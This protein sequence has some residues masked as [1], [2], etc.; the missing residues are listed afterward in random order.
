MPVYV[1]TTFNDPS[2]ATGTTVASGVN[3]MDQIV[4]FFQDVRGVHG[5]LASGGTFSTLDDPLATVGN[6]QNTQ[7]FGINDSG[8]IVGDYA[9]ASGIHGFLYDPSAGVFPPYFTL[10]DPLATG[11]EGTVA[12]GINATRQ[13]V[14][15]YEDASFHFHG[16]LLSGGVYTTLD[17]P[18]ATGATF[19]KGINGSGQIV[20]SYANAT[21]NHAFLYDPN[22]GTYTTLDDPLAGSGPGNGTFARGINDLGSSGLTPT[23]PA[24]TASSIAVAYTP[25]STIPSPPAPAPSLERLQKAS[26]I[27]ARSS[28]IIPTTPASTASL[29]PP[30]RTRRRPLG[31]RQI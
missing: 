21:G 13:I 29:K 11:A 6:A 2:A 4:G 1:F 20:G 22:G 15:Y 18:S 27:W 8:Q 28:G 3:D 7:A 17:D 24:T 26:T 14:G 31:P 16:F 30:S 25:P 23:P 12:V 5:F 19:A 10:N 9:N